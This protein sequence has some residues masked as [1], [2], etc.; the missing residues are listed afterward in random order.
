MS[1]T[2]S[3]PTG[4]GTRARQAAKESDGRNEAKGEAPA[5][6]GTPPP[7]PGP[8][9]RSSAAPTK[10]AT[11]PRR[12]GALD[13]DALVALEEERDFLLTSLDDLE[14]EHDVGDVDDVD[15]A[16]LRDDYTARAA[17]A[18]RALDQHAAVMSSSR[19]ERSWPKIAAVLAVVAV[20]AGVVGWLVADSSGRRDPGGS[21]SG[22][23]RSS[24]LG[25]IQKA[26]A[27]T[28]QAQ[29]ALSEGDSQQA[30]ELF[31]QAIAAYRAALDIDP[32]NAEALTYR[33][34]LL[35]NLYLVAGGS[36]GGAQAEQFEQGALA[37]IDD[38]LA[39][40]PAYADALVFRAII[41]EGQGRPADA[42]TDL[43][44][45]PEGSLPSEMQGMVDGLRARVQAAVDGATT[46]SVG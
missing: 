41:A 7:G 10:G 17:A 15:Y 25:E 45:L 34:W 29:Q 9:T 23:I 27:F 40:D 2:A 18:I 36:E 28:G 33:G 31:Q 43:D 39:I 32:N 30:V 12:S 37:S 35:H 24:S 19:R 16:E 1:P 13:P 42:L 14:R 22:D 20:F 46:T 21:A 4:G 44:A 6:P 38:A 3:G 8:A 11:S 26:K 5:S